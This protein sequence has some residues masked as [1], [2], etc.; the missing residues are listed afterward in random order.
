VWLTIFGPPLAQ[1]ET[2]RD[3]G[4]CASGLIVSSS[5]RVVLFPRSEPPHQ[6]GLFICAVRIPIRQ[7]I[8]QSATQPE[9]WQPTPSPCDMACWALLTLTTKSLSRNLLLAQDHAVP[10]R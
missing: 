2:S 4:A 1:P 6:N 3:P 10:C 9:L 7:M 5:A 8:S